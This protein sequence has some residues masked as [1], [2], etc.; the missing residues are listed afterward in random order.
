MRTVNKN[1][2]ALQVVVQT[3]RFYEHDCIYSLDVIILM[4]IVFNFGRHTADASWL[5]T[6][7][8]GYQELTASPGL[9]I[10]IPLSG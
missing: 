3:L 1:M 6:W 2:F 5:R 7:Q 8:S 4:F 10:R 9:A